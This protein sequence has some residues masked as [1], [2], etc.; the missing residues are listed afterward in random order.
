MRLR[1]RVMLVLMLAFV[2]LGAV[3]LGINGVLAVQ[4]FRQLEDEEV[5]AQVARLR[6]QLAHQSDDFAGKLSDWS[7]WDETWRYLS[8][9]YPAFPTEQIAGT[10]MT[11]NNIDAMLFYDRE[12]RLVH[13]QVVE[14]SGGVASSQALMERIAANPALRPVAVDGLVAG[15]FACGG[16]MAFYAAR[17]VLHADGSGPSVGT[18]VWVRDLSAARLQL[19][20]QGLNS[21]V[22]LWARDA[23]PTAVLAQLAGQDRGVLPGDRISGVSELSDQFGAPAMVG[24]VILPRQTWLAGMQTLW[25]QVA[26]S[27][28][29]LALTAGGVMWLIDHLVSRRITQLA[30][31]TAA[32]D[33][34]KVAIH[35][36]GNDEIAELANQVDDM[37]NRL[38]LARDGALAAVQAKA[39]FLATMSHEIRTPLNGVIGMSQLLSRTRLDAEQQEYA[40]IVS[41]SAEALL[42]LINDILDFSKIE[43]G[44]TEIE[45]VP[46]RLPVVLGDAAALLYGKAQEKGV[47]LVLDF[48]PDLPEC[49]I[50]DS[51]RLRQIISNLVS[52]AVKFTAKGHVRV[53]A[54]A[55]PEGD[56]LV[57]EVAVHD[58]GLGMDE[59]T[60]SRLFQSFVQANAGISRT[61]GGTGLGL[62]ISKRL[63]ELMGGTISVVSTPGVGSCFTVRIRVAVDPAAQPSVGPPLPAGA[64]VLIVGGNAV[65]AAWFGR[66]VSHW[67]GRPSLVEDSDGL[68]RAA[69]GPRPALVILD[70]LL[71]G[72]DEAMATIRS[73][74]PDLPVLLIGPPE[75]HRVPAGAVLVR[76]PVRIESL[77]RACEQ[78]L[79]GEV[80]APA[81]SAPPVPGL[82]FSG[83]V[84]LV[85]DHPINRRLGRILLEQLGVEVQEAVDGVRALEILGT[86]RF[87]LVLMDC[88]M[89][90]MDGYEATRALRSR[91]AGTG[92][93]LPVVALT[94]NAMTE[95]RDRCLAAG[96]DDFLTKPLR[97]VDLLAVVR[98]YL[99]AAT[100]GPVAEPPASPTGPAP[101]IDAATRSL[102]AGFPGEAPGVD[103]FSELIGHLCGEFAARFDE[104]AQALL[105][106]DRVGVQ[107]QA[108]ALGD[109]CRSIGLAALGGVLAEVEA[110]AERND[111]ASGVQ[112]LGL[113]EVAWQEVLAEIDKTG[114]AGVA[115]A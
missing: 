101:V 97:D 58:T 92:G 114:K 44:R 86:Q 61:Y 69:S 96:M 107:Q 22:S 12:G 63:A 38:A 53:S 95:D 91:E 9:T 2:A 90:E 25:W 1:T 93:H 37:R 6:A 16:D 84:L 109:S 87:D 98:R 79:R 33:Q 19:L 40:A 77:V 76:Q 85:D 70:Q 81:P 50:G 18:L 32:G 75:Q 49:V 24:Q 10:A 52:N 83:R 110:A 105:A 8:G 21:E 94:A 60:C 66:V 30:W 47:D 51:G 7:S 46:F 64:G 13:R 112:C 71:A 20:A 43:A 102:L 68:R 17:P 100:V 3:L 5:A 115:P 57:L 99:P 113:I 89:P 54:A 29:A 11:G 28:A 34:S 14:G 26:T 41:S 42:G 88:Q 48:A 59:A 74:W 78:A 111:L 108:K 36:A 67:G 80:Q 65:Q 45:R 4:R 62:V 103:L 72:V 39:A 31:Q 106:D 82:R 104:L 23:A 35:V 73:A 15:L 27:F 56:G 55:L